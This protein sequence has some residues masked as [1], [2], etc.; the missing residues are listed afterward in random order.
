MTPNIAIALK[1]HT[2]FHKHGQLV[3]YSL[4]WL[5]E[6]ARF[7]VVKVFYSMLILVINLE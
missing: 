6:I 5:S 1:N 2:S 7:F 4:S 3:F